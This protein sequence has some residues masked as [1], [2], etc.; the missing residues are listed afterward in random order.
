MLTATLT[1]N[2]PDTETA[3]QLRAADTTALFAEALRLITASPAVES[4]ALTA[5][6]GNRRRFSR[7]EL[8]NG[9]TQGQFE[10]LSPT[11]QAEFNRQLWNLWLNP[12]HDP[13]ADNRRSEA[14]EAAEDWTKDPEPL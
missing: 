9:L 13:L 2:Y 11:D 8:L 7:D 1:L 10:T 6:L 14:L 12:A 5:A 4:F 3:L